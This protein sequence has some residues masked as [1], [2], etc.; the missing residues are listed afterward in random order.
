MNINKVIKKE[1]DK[2]NSKRLKVYKSN[3]QRW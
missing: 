1:Y 2:K 3:K